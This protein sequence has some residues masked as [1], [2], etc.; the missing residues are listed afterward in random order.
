MEVS[1]GHIN[2]IEN[3]MGSINPHRQQ[4]FQ[5]DYQF[6][7]LS[8]ARSSV[9]YFSRPKRSSHSKA[10]GKLLKLLQLYSIFGN[11]NHIN[12]LII[13]QPFLKYKIRCSA[14][15]HIFVGWVFVGR[16]LAYFYKL[17]KS[18]FKRHS[19]LYIVDADISKNKCFIPSKLH[20]IPHDLIPHNGH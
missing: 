5:N 9:L 11:L 2:T 15:L 4:R 1:R 19:K 3:M 16:D 17:V 12:L 6:S 7:F 14:I 13:L 20:I 18:S 8:L 10:A